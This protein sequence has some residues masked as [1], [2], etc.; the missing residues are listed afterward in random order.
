MLGGVI[1]TWIAG[2][3]WKV[4]GLYPIFDIVDGRSNSKIWSGIT[5]VIVVFG[6]LALAKIILKF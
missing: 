6:V 3:V 4:E 2:P 5:A 1:Y